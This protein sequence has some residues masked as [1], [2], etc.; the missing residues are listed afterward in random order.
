MHNHWIPASHSNRPPTL[1]LGIQPAELCRLE[2][3]LSLD[4]CGSL[5]S[6]H[7]L[8]DF[9]SGSSDV[10]QDKLR[11]RRPFVLSI[12]NLLNNLAGTNI[13]ASEWK[14]YRWNAEYCENTSRLCA[15]IPRTSGRPIGM[16]LP[17]TAWVK[18][19]RRCTG[20]GQFYSSMHK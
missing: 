15:F 16:S 11:S 20:V 1:L 5:D 7:I 4:Y 2:A 17:H 3:T 18:L 6:D 12:R 19:N 13:C 10:C 8:H 14:N 9:L